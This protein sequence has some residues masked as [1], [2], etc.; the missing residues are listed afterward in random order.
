LQKCGMQL[1]VV[2]K[3]TFYTLWKTPKTAFGENITS[4]EQFNIM[5]ID[6]TGVVG[7][8]FEPYIRYTVCNAIE[9]MADDLEVAFK[10]AEVSY[11]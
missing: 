1:A 6:K 11:D 2:P 4:A 7:V 5:M 3:A 8:H 9:E 10:R